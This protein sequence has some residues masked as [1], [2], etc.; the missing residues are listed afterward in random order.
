MKDKLI[1]G[2]Y[3]LIGGVYG[4]ARSH[5]WLDKL[6]DRTITRVGKDPL[7][8]FNEFKREMVKHPLTIASRVYYMM[9]GVVYSL[10][11]WPMSLLQDFDYYQKEKM[12][13]R[14][15]RPPFPFWNLFWKD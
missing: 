1:I 13:V 15:V 8:P 7:D 6:E 3:I 11:M 5:Y 14:E 12:G 9:S 2:G 4:L 10:G